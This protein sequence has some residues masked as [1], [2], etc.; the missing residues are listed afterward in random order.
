MITKMRFRWMVIKRMRGLLRTARAKDVCFAVGPVR[1]TDWFTFDI[2]DLRDINFS[3]GTSSLGLWFLTT[4]KL[5]EAY[6]HLDELERLLAFSRSRADIEM[7]L[8]QEALDETPLAS[9]RFAK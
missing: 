4:S 2:R 6:Q 1:I 7:K 8:M 5:I 3:P 9:Q